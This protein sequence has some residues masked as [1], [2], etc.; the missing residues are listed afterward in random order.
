MN[1]L[2]PADITEE[3]F[4]PATSLPRLAAGEVDWVSGTNY[5]LP[6]ETAPP[7]QRVYGTS[8]YT[9]VRTTGVR[10]IPP[11]QDPQFWLYYGPT[12]RW[13]PFDS[14]RSTKAI[15][16]G[17]TLVYELHLGFFN[18][19]AMHEV[20]GERIKI[21][22]LDKPAS[23]GGQVVQLIERELWEQASG[24]WELLFGDLRRESTA[25]LHD[26]ELYPLG[27]LRVTITSS[28]PAAPPKLGYLSAGNWTSIIGRSTWGGTQY[29]V[30]ATPKNY[31]YKKIL[32][33]GTVELRYRGAT[34]R[35]ISGMVIMSSDEAAQALELL[36]RIGGKAV[37]IEMSD[38]AKYSHL[39]TVGFV[40]G[41]VKSENWSM[42]SIS[43][44]VEG[45]I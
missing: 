9:L 19:I 29:G 44:T 41:T 10:N 31:T 21:E 3:M 24:L 39:R 16:T 36:E 7:L 26:L 40:E 15:G 2:I 28:N 30:Q 14:Y 27:V 12:T 37:A 13:A 35:N 45:L 1:I 20:E 33:D 23:L 18:G 32:S 8:I 6:A 25:S 42:A 5:T 38:L 22:I 17:G 34:S 43:I 4:G 11:P